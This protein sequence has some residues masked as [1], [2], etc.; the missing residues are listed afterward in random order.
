[1]LEDEMERKTMNYGKTIQRIQ[2][3]VFTQTGSSTRGKIR[4]A[5]KS[6]KQILTYTLYGGQ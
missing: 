4:G 3:L 6:S 1:M 2:N 5:Q